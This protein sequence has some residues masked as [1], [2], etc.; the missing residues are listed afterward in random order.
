MTTP[1][2]TPTKTIAGF[3]VLKN[4]DGS[5]LY[6]ETGTYNLIHK[7]L[8][9]GSNLFF[10][11]PAG[12]AKTELAWAIF[13]ERGV[14]PFQSEFGATS[15]GSELDGMVTL[16]TDGR[17]CLIP[18]ELYK[19]IKNAAAGNKTG[20]VADELNRAQSAAA[21][22][23]L[24]RLFSGQR[25]YATDFDGVLS[26]GHNL[27]TIGTAN[28]GYHGTT[29]LNEALLDR[30]DAV[31]FKPITGNVLAVML[32]ERF[33]MVKAQDIGKIVKFSD[34]VL[35]ITESD[36]D[37]DLRP[38]SVRDAQRIARGVAAGLTPIEAVTRLVGGQLL[39]QQRGQDA[40]EALTASAKGKLS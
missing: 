4:H 40:V 28:I 37:G 23:K 9:L 17:P 10:F 25:E 18:S 14:D 36:P 24:L 6:I 34:A 29:R 20:L 27:Q 13:R 16:G 15:V 1:T 33:P 21:L 38:I 19:A 22:N 31:E 30:F 35:K 12:T 32:E 3:T 11:G 2:P 8:D 5:S 26:V 39:I 7:L